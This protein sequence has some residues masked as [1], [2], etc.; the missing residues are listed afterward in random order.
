[1]ARPTLTKTRI[2]NPTAFVGDAPEIIPDPSEY[3]GTYYK[4]PDAKQPR[5]G[6]GCNYSLCIVKDDPRGN[7]HR[8]RC[9]PEY[10]LEEDDAGNMVEVKVHPGFTWEG[11]AGQFKAQFEKA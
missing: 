9:E 8:L 4:V 5:A 3:S 11:D 7:T 10:V 2:A 1:M 6:D